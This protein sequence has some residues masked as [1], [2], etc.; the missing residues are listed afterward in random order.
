M[1]IQHPMHR[2]H[3]QFKKKLVSSAIFVNAL[4]TD[5]NSRHDFVVEWDQ[6][7]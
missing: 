3:Q 4:E 2:E 7:P 5:Y 6:A 1:A